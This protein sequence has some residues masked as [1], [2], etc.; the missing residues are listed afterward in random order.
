MN[1]IPMFYSF[2]CERA[3]LGRTAFRCILCGE[4]DPVLLATATAL[5]SHT[6]RADR[7]HSTSDALAFTSG[8]LPTKGLA[9]ADVLLAC[10][11]VCITAR[12]VLHRHGWMLRFGVHT[13][14]ATMTPT[15]FLALQQR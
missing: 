7:E 6:R 14:I 15:S 8:G 10:P 12:M 9:I 2:T 11:G 13:L 3:G 1:A 4:P 5:H